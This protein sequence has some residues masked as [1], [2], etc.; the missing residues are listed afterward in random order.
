MAAGI[1]YRKVQAVRIVE[2]ARRE[3]GMPEIPHEE[4]LATPL[5]RLCVLLSEATKVG[6]AKRGAGLFGLGLDDAGEV[7]EDEERR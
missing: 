3:A 1:P 5:F 4:L 6:I 2:R 7:Q